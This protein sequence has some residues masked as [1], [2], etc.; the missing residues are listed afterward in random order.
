ML[1]CG[2]LSKSQEEKILTHLNETEFLSPFGI[3]SL[4]KKDPGYDLNDP[5]WGGPGVYAG[6]AP[7]LIEDL[8]QSGYPEKAEDILK[9]ILW[10]GKYLPYYPQAIVADQ[11]DYRR[12]GRANVIAGISSTQSILFGVLGLQVSHDG[13]TSILVH[14]NRLFDTFRLEGLQVQGK[15]ISVRSEGNHLTVSLQGGMEIQGTFGQ[16]IYF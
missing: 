11:V 6:D 8:Y 15:N 3:H 2:I 1:R 7:E 4:S 12:N 14:K 16:R 9:R 5:D 10:W 13:K